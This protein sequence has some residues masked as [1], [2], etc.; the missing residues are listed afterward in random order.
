MT[1]DHTL[2]EAL[3][4]PENV[5]AQVFTRLSRS[6]QIRRGQPAFH[7]DAPQQVLPSSP[8][9]L[10]LLRTCET[11]RVLVVASFSAL[12]QQIDPEDLGL[13]ALQPGADQTVLDLLTGTLHRADRP[14]FLGPYQVV[15]LELESS[16]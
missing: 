2:L 1:T 6:L 14:L 12:E 13:C 5:Q 9:L 11:Q 16:H 8:Q 10:R 4:T 7:P 15:W 3:D